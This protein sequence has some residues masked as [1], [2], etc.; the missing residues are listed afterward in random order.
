MQLATAAG[1]GVVSDSGICVSEFSAE[2]VNFQMQDFNA[3]FFQRVADNRYEQV[4]EAETRITLEYTDTAILYYSIQKDGV[5]LD[6]T[7]SLDD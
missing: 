3:G 7:L 2:G 5:F 6:L 4:T 1:D